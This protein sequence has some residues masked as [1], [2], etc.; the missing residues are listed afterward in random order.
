MYFVDPPLLGWG[1]HSPQGVDYVAQP[2]GQK[3]GP[4]P[5]PI[6]SNPRKRTSHQKGRVPGS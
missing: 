4:E 1:G 2:G 5:S 3:S 6:F